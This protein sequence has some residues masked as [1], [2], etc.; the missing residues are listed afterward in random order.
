[1]SRSQ[2]VLGSIISG[3]GG[4]VVLFALL[5]LTYITKIDFTNT[6]FVSPTALPGIQVTTQ[7]AMGGSWQVLLIELLAVIAIVFAVI[8]LFTG[9]AADTPITRKATKVLIVLGLLVLV[10][11]FL[12]YLSYSGSFIPHPTFYSFSQQT[13]IYTNGAKATN[14]TSGSSLAY[15]YSSGFWLYM[16]GMVLIIIG[17]GISVQSRPIFRRVRKI[18]HNK[19]QRHFW[20]VRSSIFS[21]QWNLGLIISGI[22]GLLS[23]FA[24]LLLPYITKAQVLG[25][26]IQLTISTASQLTLSGNWIFLLGG[27]LTVILAACIAWQMFTSRIAKEARMIQITMLMIILSSLILVVSLILYSSS[28][29]TLVSHTFIRNPANNAPTFT[30]SSD[31]TFI[32]SAN[33]TALSTTRVVGCIEAALS[34]DYGS[35]FW[36]YIAGI[37][38]VLVGSL[39]RIRTL[40]TEKESL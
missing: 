26:D 8:Q 38:L 21:S 10:A 39:E 11:S 32:G 9:K 2:Q 7:G 15:Y 5:R 30:C 33:P 22:G 35:G 18:V 14:G 20:E 13:E 4:V 25:S 34:I 12:P 23:L 17:I 6:S 19:K 29:A 1:M 36:L 40:R 28:S 3:I 27:L 31:T 24:F 16:I 37:I